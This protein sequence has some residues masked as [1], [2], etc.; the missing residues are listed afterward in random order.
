MSAPQ[1]SAPVPVSAHSDAQAATA[2]SSVDLQRFLNRVVVDAN[3]HANWLNTLS[4][5]EF[6]GTRKIARSLGE[7]H[8]NRLALQH[9]AEEARHAYFF[10]RS[11]E[12]IA[13]ERDPG[14]AL[15]EMIAG[16][17]AARYFHRLDAHVNAD[18]AN[19]EGVTKQQR[20]E[21]C[22]LYVTTMIEERAGWMYST[23]DAVL[24]RI[25]SPVRLSGIIAEEEQHLADMFSAATRLDPNASARLQRYRAFEARSFAPFF[26]ALL[27]SVGP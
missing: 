16:Y 3:R 17:S 1:Q 2:F 12:R 8:A 22:Y 18:I 15:S 9:L 6:M 19:T 11:I 24:E 13:P 27:K 21:L 23:Y 14:F 10:K 20:A 4:F 25:D 7:R 5:L 26:A